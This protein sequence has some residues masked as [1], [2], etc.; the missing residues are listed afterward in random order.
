MSTSVQLPTD[1]YSPDQ[2]S[3]II[4]EL[5]GHSSSLRDANVRARVVRAEVS[6]PTHL[7]ALLLGVLR[8]T[9]IS[10]TDQAGAEQLLK[11]LEAIRDKAPAVHLMMAALPNRALKR[12][13]TEWFRTEIHPFALLTFATR[14]DIG[15]GVIIQAGSRIYDYS[16]RQQILG[17]KHRI[18]EIFQSVRQ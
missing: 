12:Q 7:S 9:N 1:L 17:H 10:T 11:G 15:G 3:A 2:L 18:S 14:A 4:I 6:A 8:S 13:L 16:F 5:R